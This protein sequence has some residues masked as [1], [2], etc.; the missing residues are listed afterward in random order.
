MTKKVIIEL[1]DT[2]D[3]ILSVTAV[4]VNVGITDVTTYVVDLSKGTHIVH[5]GMKWLQEK[6]EG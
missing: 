2:Y 5:N 1:P 3:D 6:V 4:G